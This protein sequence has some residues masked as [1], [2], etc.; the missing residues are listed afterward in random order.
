MSSLEFVHIDYDD[1]KDGTDYFSILASLAPVVSESSSLQTLSI[2]RLHEADS[3]LELVTS[4]RLPSVTTLRVSQL[5]RITLAPW[6]TVV[7]C[8]LFTAA[9]VYHLINNAPLLDTLHLQ[10]DNRGVLASLRGAAEVLTAVEQQP[11]TSA[12]KLVR[13]AVFDSHVHVPSCLIPMMAQCRLLAKLR[14]RIS[15]PSW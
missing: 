11:F 15:F 9:D 8:D 6:L 10:L 7:R 1:D 4:L 13:T 12:I 2:T 5:P 14:M 3:L